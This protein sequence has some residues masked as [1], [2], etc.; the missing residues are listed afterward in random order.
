M[1]LKILQT[2]SFK[3]RITLFTLA[4]FM[5]SIWS[6]TIYSSHILHRDIGSELTRQ[7]F[8]VVSILA[9]HINDNLDDRFGALKDTSGLIT[10]A[11]MSNTAALQT[12][13]EQLPVLQSHFNGGTFVTRI[14]GT[15]IASVPVSVERVGVN[16][17]ER[18]HVAAALKEGMSRMSQV[19]IGKKLRAPVTS[20]AAPIRDAQG[21]VIGALVGVTNLAKPKFFDRITRAHYG[22]TGGFLL[23]SPKQRL[24]VT[25]TDKERIMEALPAPGINPAIDRH[26]AGYEGSDLF[27][28]AEGVEVRLDQAHS[29]SGL[30]SDHSATDSRSLLPRPRH[31]A[32]NDAG[33]S[34]AFIACRLAD[35]V[36]V[37]RPAHT[38]V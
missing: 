36:D 15:A 7:Q 12:F 27:I 8:S 31:G 1:I 2:L 3:A 14:D 9:A 34:P 35:L 4:I 16:Y 33:C 30:V 13:L 29:S 19:V 22:K 10:P 11:L 18:D 6:L 20:I 24:I 5:I 23:V 25:A 37:A 21:N 28:N 32:A 17:M 26:I 38:D